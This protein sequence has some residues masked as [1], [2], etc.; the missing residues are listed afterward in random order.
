MVKSLKSLILDQ[1]GAAEVG[2]AIDPVTQLQQERAT[3]LRPMDQPT[4]RPFTY[5]H[6]LE[7]LILLGELALDPV[8]QFPQ[9]QATQLHN[10]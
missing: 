1:V 3:K 8:T 2:V 7:P 5:L 9:E 4:Q 6:Y 10:L